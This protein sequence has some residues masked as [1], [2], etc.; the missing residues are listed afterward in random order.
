MTPRPHDDR[1]PR[2]IAF[3]IIETVFSLESLRPGL[4][5]LGLPTSALETWFAASLRDA[6]ALATTG[7]FAPFRAVMAD[8]LADLLQR[9]GVP[10]MEN[11][12]A[13]FLDGMKTL[14]AQP[15]AA[16]ALSTLRTAD[17]PIIALSNGAVGAT[18]A[19]LDRAGLR[20]LFQSVLSVEDVGLSKPRGEVYGHAAS[21]LGMPPRGSVPRCRPC[22]GCAWRQG[23]WF[24]DGLRLARSALPCDHARPGRDRRRT[25]RYG[26][27]HQRTSGLRDQAFMSMT[28]FVISAA[29]DNTF[30]FALKAATERS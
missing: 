18:E 7:G 12:I 30:A 29:V 8:A 21:V 3:D 5:P 28:V 20:P 17:M 26:K 19:L 1:R 9:H 23:R 6:F 11:R 13:A 22:L 27:G 4:T 25:G 10:V 24:E 15:D 14:N 16:E 2:A